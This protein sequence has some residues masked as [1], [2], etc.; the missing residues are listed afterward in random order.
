MRARVTLSLFFFICC[1]MN[2]CSTTRAKSQT[3]STCVSPLPSL[4]KQQLDVFKGNYP[5]QFAVYHIIAPTD[6][7]ATEKL[8]HYGILTVLFFSKMPKDFSVR[9]VRSKNLEAKAFYEYP[10][11]FEFPIQ[12]NVHFTTHDG[13]EEE[14]IEQDLYTIFPTEH[15]KMKS[16][17][18]LET[19]TGK[20]IPLFTSPMKGAEKLGAKP[21]SEEL[22]DM[23][24]LAQL[25]LD[26]YC[27]NPKNH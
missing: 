17:W 22:P 27:M 7:E 3:E 16:S 14:F 6:P 11:V 13:N 10:S 9:K 23:K 26:E 15:L 5:E 12:K 24:Q 21:R 20:K 8:N 25:V 18:E 4:I 19:I 1:F 2:A